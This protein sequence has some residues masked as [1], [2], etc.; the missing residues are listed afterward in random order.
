MEY[1]SPSR[2]RTYEVVSFIEITTES[3]HDPHR[4]LPRCI[5]TQTLCLRL[6]EP[7]TESRSTL[8][9]SECHHSL[10]YIFQKNLKLD[11]G[12]PGWWVITKE[13][14][15]FLKR[16]LPLKASTLVKR[17]TLSIWFSNH[18]FIRFGN[19]GLASWRADA[20][21]NALCQNGFFRA[22]FWL[23]NALGR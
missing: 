22:Q 12:N 23:T 1:I 19:M 14:L 3:H 8:R 5:S 13:V 16:L 20:L 11:K 9:F 7:N 15:P 18:N 21:T 4:Q 2:L 17:L 6:L 10:S